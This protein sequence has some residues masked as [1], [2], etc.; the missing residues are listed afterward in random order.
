MNSQDKGKAAKERLL[1][2]GAILFAKNGFKGVSVREICDKA[3]TGN[4]M[5]HHYF[6]S[7]KGLYDSLIQQ[8]T[9]EVF[10]VPVRVIQKEP[11]TEAE[12]IS[13]FELFVEET[14]EAMI[15]NRFLF[16]L[17]QNE[18]AMIDQNPFVEYAASFISFIEAAK[19]RGFVNDVI[20][21]EM[22]TGFILDRLGNQVLHAS[23]IKRNT[24]LDILDD[25]TYRA[26]W[27]RANLNL[28]LH[29]F[30]GSISKIDS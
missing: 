3:G 8:F 13:R 24:G 26:K 16:V 7:K 4:N 9:A 29:G 30:I 10:S 28:F 22:L 21:P 11:S 14:L 5:I 1:E 12:F 2:H 27:L 6:G 20:E 19:K 18:A 25:A 23:T 15:S 17:V